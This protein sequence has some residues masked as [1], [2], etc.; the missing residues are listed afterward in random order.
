MPL[1]QVTSGSTAEISDV[2][3][4]IQ[5]LEGSNTYIPIH[6]VTS[7][8]DF[9]MRLS[10]SAGGHFFYVQDSASAL[11]FHVDSNGN[12]K[13]YNNLT[14]T[15]TATPGA[16]QLPVSATPNIVTAGLVGYDSTYKTLVFGDGSNTVKVG[17]LFDSN[18]AIESANVTAAATSAMRPY[19]FSGEAIDGG[20][21]S[22]SS[23]LYAYDPDTTGGLL[24]QWDMA[25]T[26]EP[27]SLNIASATGIYDESGLTNAVNGC[28]IQS[29]YV[30]AAE[31]LY[32]FQ[33]SGSGSPYTLN[34]KRYAAGAFSSGTSGAVSLGTAITST[35]AA[36]VMHSAW[37]G[38][39]IWL[40]TA[41]YGGG[42]A[43]VV[44]LTY[45]SLGTTITVGTAWAATPTM[46]YGI[47]SNGTYV[48]LL[49]HDGSNI[50]NIYKYNAT[51]TLQST[52]PYPI[53]VGN[54]GSKYNTLPAQ[55]NLCKIRNHLVMLYNID[56]AGAE[57]SKFGGV[58]IN[59][60]GTGITA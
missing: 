57:S 10:D 42:G 5:A 28:A 40:Y 50:T 16:L 24:Q 12:A 32:V 20:P 38:T 44:P 6:V 48:W 4:L 53:L 25:D 34:V 18:F 59:D 52:T 30:N 3:Q 56:N 23:T 21:N 14:V 31:Y 7:G 37:D 39:T 1:N 60:Y 15:G 8:S 22:N 17:P 9:V 49:G 2:N 29:V 58:Q 26:S 51:G 36:P 13:V 35:V 19:A 54:G 41:N 45:N 43:Q 33:L 46:V 47:W 55:S 11:K 27:S